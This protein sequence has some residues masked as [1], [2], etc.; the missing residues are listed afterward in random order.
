MPKFIMRKILLFFIA[1]FMAQTTFAQ[2]KVLPSSNVKN[3]EG[4]SLN[5]QELAKSGKITVVS[6]WAIWCSPC[7]KELDAINDY[8][9]EWQ[10][11]YGLEVV[12]VSIDD[13]RTV[14][15]VKGVVEK[16]GWPFRIILDTQREFMQAMS[17]NNPPYTMLLD[18]EGNIVYEHLGYTPGDELELEKKIKA[19]IK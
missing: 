4:Q 15:N 3:M 18:Q 5:V 10:E 2:S 7:R 14:A 8:Y 1:L 16:H 6:F 19:L 11:K 17:V 13:A 12:A 9:E